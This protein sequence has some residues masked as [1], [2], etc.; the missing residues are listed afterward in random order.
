MESKEPPAQTPVRFAPTSQFNI[1]T[2]LSNISASMPNLYQSAAIPSAST[3]LAHH[4]QQQPPQ[5]Q[6]PPA[7]A[8]KQPAVN[9]AHD[10]SSMSLLESAA[11]V[12][13]ST[14]SISGGQV[15]HLESA[16]SVQTAYETLRTEYTHSLSKLA[17]IRAKLRDQYRHAKQAVEDS[18]TSLE[19]SSDESS[20]LQA[21]L[22]AN[23]DQLT[24]LKLNAG[25]SR[26]HAHVLSAKPIPLERSQAELKA[27]MHK[28]KNIDQ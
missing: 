5:Q 1:S 6:Q 11:V 7:P 22:A 21:R 18:A 16:T 23:V 20:E 28:N 17:S 25:A 10:L 8:A 9:I 13:K 4:P 24:K 15:L 14:I 27:I 2:T 26:Q 12:G 3:I 19:R